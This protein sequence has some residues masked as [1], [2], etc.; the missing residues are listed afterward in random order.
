MKKYIK[1]YSDEVKQIVQC[2]ADERVRQGIPLRTLAAELGV[3]PNW[4]QQVLDAQ[5]NPQLDSVVK[6]GNALGIT[7]SMDNTRRYD[8][9]ASGLIDLLAKAR[10]YQEISTREL[11]EMTGL[12]LPSVTGTLSHR[13]MPR[14]NGFLLIADALGVKL[15]LYSGSNKLL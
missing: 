10:T 4:V 9:D 2:L 3:Y 8:Y 11:A 1:P 14:L 12:A 7:F 6:V 13:T 5:R 15:E